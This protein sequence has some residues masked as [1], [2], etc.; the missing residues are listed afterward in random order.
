MA[1]RWRTALEER[2]DDRMEKGEAEAGARSLESGADL[3]GCLLLWGRGGEVQDFNPRS[4]RPEEEQNF[5]L[6]AA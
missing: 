3:H 5:E 4:G 1:A 2:R 6:S